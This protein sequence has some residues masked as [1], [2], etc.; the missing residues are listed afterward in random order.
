M[1]TLCTAKRLDEFFQS[2]YLWSSLKWFLHQHLSWGGS[3]KGSIKGMIPNRR[4]SK[5]GFIKSIKR[6]ETW[7]KSSREM[8]IWNHCIINCGMQLVTSDLAAGE[9]KIAIV[10]WIFEKSTMKDLGN[11]GSVML[12]SVLNSLVGSTRRNSIHSLRAK[13]NILRKRQHCF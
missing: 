13:C 4:V 6:K 10:L 3:R 5:I 9:Y 11:C 12:T 2:C 1:C 8:D 7:F